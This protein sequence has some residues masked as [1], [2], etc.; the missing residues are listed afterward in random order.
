MLFQDPVQTIVN[1]TLRARCD[2][3]TIGKLKHP[4][5]QELLQKS[6][7]ILTTSQIMYQYLENQRCNKNHHHDSV[8][9]GYK[10]KDGSWR[11]VSEYTELYTA[12]FSQ[13][14]ART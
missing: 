2:M 9:G 7:Q 14:I 3:C 1:N 11:R 12:L 6:T 10:T 4:G 13:R 8:A 5:S